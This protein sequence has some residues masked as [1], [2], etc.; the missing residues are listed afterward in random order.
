MAKSD[1]RHAYEVRV[2]YSEVDMQGV[3]FNAHFMNYFD[4]ANTE[5]VYEVRRSLSEEVRK[6]VDVQLVKSTIEFA[7]PARLHEDLEVHARVARLG[8]SSMTFLYEIY[9]KGED[10]LLSTCE[11]VYVNVD[12]EASKSLP[13]PEEFI[14]AVLEREQG[15]VER[16]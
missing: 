1:F 8:R 7:A 10:E 5:Y 16:S 14:A 13:M 9:R 11:A 6:R 12:L 15:A 2:R 3:V 4:I